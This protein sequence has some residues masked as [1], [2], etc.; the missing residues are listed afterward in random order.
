MDLNKIQNTIEAEIEKANAAERKRIVSLIKDFSKDLI[1]AIVNGEEDEA[2]AKKPAAKKPVK[3]E[4]PVEEEKEEAADAEP[5]DG[6]EYV[7]DIDDVEDDEIEESEYADKK[8][9]E[10]RAICKER[11]ITIPK[12]FKQ[13]EIQKLLILIDEDQE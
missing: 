2:P 3:K 5:V 13:K 4:E 7:D 6:N 1:D 9:G 11:N 10:L 12:G 8:V